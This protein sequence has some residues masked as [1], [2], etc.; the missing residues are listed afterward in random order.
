MNHGDKL[1]FR[2]AMRAARSRWFR[3]HGLGLVEFPADEGADQQAGIACGPAHPAV[4][5]HAH[6]SLRKHMG[7]PA[8]EEFIDAQSDDVRTVGAALMAE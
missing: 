1:H 7:E 6:E 4:V 5:S 3:Q 2:P 8:P